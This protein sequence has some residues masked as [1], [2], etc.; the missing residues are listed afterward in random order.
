[1]SNAT[2]TVIPASVTCHAARDPSVRVFILA[3]ML[4]GIGIWCLVDKHKYDPPDAWDIKH[5]NDA[6]GYVF[7]HYTPYVSIPLG[8]LFVIVG[9]RI[10]RR[11]LVADSAGIGYLG[12]DKLLWDQIDKLDVSKFKSKGILI[13]LAR[14]GGKTRRLKLDSWKLKNFRDLVV[15]VEA[16]APSAAHSQA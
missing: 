9:V 14:E 13:L 10:L 8:G 11:V 2:N 5:I 15:F 6:A 16:H 4:L 3:A 7:N 1:M 12:K